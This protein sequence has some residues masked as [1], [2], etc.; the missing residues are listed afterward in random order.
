MNLL[1]KIIDTFDGEIMIDNQWRVDG[2]NG[3]KYTVK[4]DKFHKNYSC[5]C[6]GYIYRRRCK[7]ITQISDSFKKQYGVKK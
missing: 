2:S 6:L 3:K 7:H 4:W 5:E 1:D